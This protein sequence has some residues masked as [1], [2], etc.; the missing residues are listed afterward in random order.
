VRIDRAYQSCAGPG[1]T[2][3][4]IGGERLYVTKAVIGTVLVGN[5]GEL[6]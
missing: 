1:C 3:V 5:I 4:A 2:N 6:G